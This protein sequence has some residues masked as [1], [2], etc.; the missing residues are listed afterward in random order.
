MFRLLH[1]L[2]YCNQYISLQCARKVGKDSI[3]NAIGMPIQFLVAFSVS[4]WS[5]PTEQAV[6]GG[7]AVD[8]H[9]V[10]PAPPMNLFQGTD[11]DGSL[12][13]EQSII[14]TAARWF[15]FGGVDEDDRFGLPARQVERPVY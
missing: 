7:L 4:R 13:N 15:A 11:I 1:T 10:E 9:F 8:D 3:A 5:I 14:M 2:C 12:G 6:F